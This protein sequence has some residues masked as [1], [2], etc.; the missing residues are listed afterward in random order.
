MR[1]NST[2]IL[3]RA[4]Q[5]VCAAT[6][7]AII[8]CQVDAHNDKGGDKV[9]IS[10]PFG[11]MSVKT[12]AQAVGAVVGLDVY[13]GATL[14][15]KDHDDGAADVNMNFGSFH[16]GVK[17]MS[18]RTSDNPAKVLAFYRS[19]M[20]KF[21]TVIECKGDRPVS[22][23]D[24]TQDG[25]TCSEEQGGHPQINIDSDEHN[26]QLKAGSKRHQHIVAV[27]QKD[28]Y[29]KIGLVALDLPDGFIDGDS[30]SQ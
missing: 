27:S 14:V 22:P 29:T 11:G 20:T 19:H 30:S 18:Y 1:S 7:L 25:L 24:S 8:G 9:N 17:A 28:G 13:P 26:L 2:Q 21:G 4:G 10:T 23:P 16:L 5:V 12:N 15:E 3:F 6:L